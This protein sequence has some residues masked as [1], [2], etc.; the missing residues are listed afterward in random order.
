MN[1]GMIVRLFERRFHVSQTPP[2]YVSKWG[3]IE[4]ASGVAVDENT[5]LNST[6]VWACVNILAQ[7]VASLP[8]ILY[9]RVGTNKVRA[10]DHPLY[11]V[12]HD[13]P[14]E[15]MTSVE[16]RETLQ[17]H[18]ATWGNAFAEIEYDG[19]GRV[20]ALWPWRPDRARMERVNGQLFYGFRERATAEEKFYPGWKILHVRGLGSN[21]LWGYS[22]IAME[23]QA[24]GLAMATEE[25]GARFFGN[26]AAPGGVLEH[27][28]HLGPEAF[29]NLKTSWAETHQGLENS[30]RI[31]ILEEG[32]KYQQV[33]IPPE[34]AQFLETRKFQLAE[35]ARIFR[36]PPHM[37]ADLEKATFSNIEHQSIEYV[38][39]SLRPWLV[40]WEQRLNQRLLTEAEQKEYYF[41]FLVDGL[42]RGDI[43]SRYQA[44]AI[45][46]QWGWLSTNDVREIENMNDVDGGDDYWVPMNMGVAGEEKSV[47]TLERSNV[48]TLRTD[49]RNDSPFAMQEEE[50]RSLRNSGAVRER[51]RLA[52]AHEVI[53]E[54]ALGRAIK[55]EVQDLRAGAKKYLSQ[56]D[57]QGWEL[58]LGDFYREHERSIY[59][60]LDPPALAYGMQVNDAAW[61]EAEKDAEELTQ[62]QVRFIRSLVATYASQHVYDNQER[63]QTVVREAVAAGTDP[64]QAVEEE[65]EK[66]KDSQAASEAKEEVNRQGNA[67]AQTTYALAGARASVWVQVGD[68]CPYCKTLDGRVVELSKAFLDVGDFKV[69]G[70]EQVLTIRRIRKHPPAHGGCD[71]LTMVSW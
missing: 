35:I 3:G 64:V 9:R 43:Q 37:I 48:G 54:D 13:Q 50:L 67:L 4:T 18:L 5:A 57:E 24:I 32:L 38:T 30:H 63:I 39:H 69:E 60:F 47:G 26:G 45:G 8:L 42:L 65:T 22:P 59:K 66:W 12:M 11:R 25:Y 68:S 40:R 16:W 55:R 21:G 71:C 41:E 31:A 28:G 52:K 10:V 19:A 1:S 34:D 33:G 56:R 14:N 53:F 46:K 70:V 7:D 51:R 17:G 44:Y 15:E 29:E 2:G 6:A 27:P 23:R 58:W 61:K 62:N 49:F 20:V 36:I